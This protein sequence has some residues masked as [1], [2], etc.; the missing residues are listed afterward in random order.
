[1]ELL[2]DA[3]AGS[4]NCSNGVTVLAA[5]EDLK[6]TQRIQKSASNDVLLYYLGVI[7]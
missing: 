6:S 3:G 2:D 1:L 5:S 4:A 7:S